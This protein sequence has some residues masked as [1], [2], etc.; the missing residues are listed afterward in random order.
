VLQQTTVAEFLFIYLN[1]IFW[2]LHGKHAFANLEHPVRDWGNEL[3]KLLNLKLQSQNAPPPM[4]SIS[5]CKC[6]ILK[7]L[8]N[9]T[10]LPN[11]L[12]VVGM[13]NYSNPQQL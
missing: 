4:F 1:D 5:S 6:R 3:R 9:D 11:V 12:V 7:Y 8:P 10:H 2:E 13:S